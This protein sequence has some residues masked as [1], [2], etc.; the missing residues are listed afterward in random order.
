[1]RLLSDNPIKFYTTLLTEADE[2][3]DYWQEKLL[4]DKDTEWVQRKIKNTKIAI[5]GYVKQLEL[6]KCA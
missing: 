5:A 3:L 2:L 1:M 4:T 6:L